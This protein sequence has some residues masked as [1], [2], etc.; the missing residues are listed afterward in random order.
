MTAV[1]V[2]SLVPGADSY[3][4]DP[5]PLDNRISRSWHYLGDAR[6][7][8]W[9][10]GG[11]AKK[12]ESLYAHVQT[13]EILSLLE[14]AQSRGVSRPSSYGALFR[15]K[16]HSPFVARYALRTM[17]HWPALGGWQ[18]LR[19]E[20]GHY[21][22]VWR[23]YDL[24][25][26]YLWAL[27]EGLPDPTTYRFTRK[28][29]K[30]ESGV[31]WAICRPGYNAPYPYDSGG[32]LPIADWEIDAYGINAEIQYGITWSRN[33]PTEPIYAAIECW[34]CWREVARAYWGSWASTSSVECKSYGKKL[35]SWMLPPRYA[36]P[37]WAHLI[38]AR[39]RHRIWQVATNAARVYV[40]SVLTQAELPL[41][42]EI[43]GWTLKAT[44]P[45]GITVSNL[46][47]IYPITEGAH[48]NEQRQQEH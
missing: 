22:G 32:M 12:R 20:P 2:D 26:A 47:A 3:T 6:S 36:N 33:S 15:G 43:G 27:G 40:D 38:T 17:A 37:I 19:L 16:Y 8:E 45:E 9:K 25:G 42:L 24:R 35:S 7:I 28:L 31:Y 41:S 5:L 21:P 14:E 48:H 13:D 30:S 29:V 23:L 34:S 4:L 18:E 44:A 46:N 11:I 1:L 10:A 39:V